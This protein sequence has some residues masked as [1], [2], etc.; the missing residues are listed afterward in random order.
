[1]KRPC[2]FVGGVGDG[3]W[4]DIDDHQNDHILAVFT[5]SEISSYAEFENASL[6]PGAYTREEIY[7]RRLW[8]ADGKRFTMFALHS[9][10]MIDVTEALF[11]GYR[12]P[13]A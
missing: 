7:T 8:Q 6:K 4:I 10:S 5:S 11:S 3:R 12:R 1:M 13:K 9:M 2:L